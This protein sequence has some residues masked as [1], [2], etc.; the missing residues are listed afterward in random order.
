MWVF[1]AKASVQ[2]DGGIQ[3]KFCDKQLFNFAFGLLLA[4]YSLM[5]FFCCCACCLTCCVGVA[6]M[7]DDDDN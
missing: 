4:Q 6:A 5:G 7:A 1:K 2:F 3:D